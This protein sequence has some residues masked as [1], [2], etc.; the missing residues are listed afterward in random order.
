MERADVQPAARWGLLGPTRRGC[1]GGAAPCEGA[2][3]CRRPGVTPGC[4]PPRGPLKASLKAGAQRFLSVP[5]VNTIVFPSLS[6]RA[7]AEDRGVSPPGE[8][9]AG[10]GGKPISSTNA[11]E[12]PSVKRGSSCPRR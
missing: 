2:A 8:H 10:R 9:N 4:L 11:G 5:F 6:A 1:A 3:G 12:A 7:L